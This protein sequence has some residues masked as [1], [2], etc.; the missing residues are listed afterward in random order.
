MPRPTNC[1][2]IKCPP[3]MLGYRPFGMERCR[4][5]S[6]KL[7]Y[8]EFESIKMIDYLMLSQEEAAIQMNISRPTFTRLYN[9]ALKSV[10]RAFAEGKCIDIEGGN[11]VMENDW[12]R[13]RRCKKVIEGIDNHTKCRDC[14]S[15]NNTELMKINR[16]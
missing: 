9:S 15:F 11:Y 13:C 10:A 7:K 4:S 2:K 8:E 3:P 6:V 5:G 14:D 12:Y 1:R 16:G